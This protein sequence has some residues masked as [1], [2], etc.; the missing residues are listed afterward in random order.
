MLAHEGI[1]AALDFVVVELQARAQKIRG[2][3]DRGGQ[4]VP[5][6]GARA[7]HRGG[8]GE[9][10]VGAKG[11]QTGGK[12]VGDGMRSCENRRIA[13]FRDRLARSE[14]GRDHR[15]IRGRAIRRAQ[16]DQ[17]RSRPCGDNFA[18]ARSGDCEKSDIEIPKIGGTL[19]RIDEALLTGGVDGLRGARFGGEEFQFAELES[20]RGDQFDKLVADRAGGADNRHSRLAGNTHSPSLSVLSSFSRTRRPIALHPTVCVPAPP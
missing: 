20:A 2:L 8:G 10:T 6:A 13:Q 3:I 16:I 15:H 1:E 7:E 9:S 17:N 12:N 11:L 19:E 18:G 5:A 4:H 14:S